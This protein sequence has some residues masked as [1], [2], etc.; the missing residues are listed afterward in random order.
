MS[1]GPAPQT[2]SLWGPWDFREHTAGEVHKADDKEELTDHGGVG[3]GVCDQEAGHR[4]GGS[5][6]SPERKR[7]G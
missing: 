1:S 3:K 6:K 4:G 7:N 5:S 2:S